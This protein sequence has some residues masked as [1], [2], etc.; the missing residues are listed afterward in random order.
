MSSMNSI[1]VPTNSSLLGAT[2]I[3]NPNV[4]MGSGSSADVTEVKR[5]IAS[6]RNL[7]ESSALT[8]DVEELKKFTEFLKFRI[9]E[10]DARL[11]LLEKNNSDVTSK[12]NMMEISIT[13]L[14]AV[15][16]KTAAD[17]S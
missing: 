6:L 7:V 3:I 16:K 5:D 15:L 1:F 4:G 12:I 10:L 11:G 9:D 14:S 8:N 2:G 13:A 17:S